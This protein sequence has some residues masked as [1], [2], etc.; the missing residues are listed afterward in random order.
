MYQP[1]P[2]SPS[3]APEPARAKPPNSVQNAVWLMYAGAAQRH[4]AEIAAVVTAVILLFSKESA[5]YFAK[6]ASPS[7]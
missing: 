1:Y 6:S 2:S 7:G 4:N 3:Q 5:P